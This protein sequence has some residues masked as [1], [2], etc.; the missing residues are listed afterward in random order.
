MENRNLPVPRSDFIGIENIIHLATGGEPPLL[1]GHRNAF[2]KFAKD[3]AQ[4]MPGYMRHWEQ[5]EAARW[6]LADFFTLNPEDIGLIGNASEGIVKVL[7]SI[8]WNEGDNVVVSELDY[9]SGRYALGNLKRRGVKVRMVP[10]TGWYI[11][12]DDLKNAC[13]DKTRVVYISQVNATTGQFIDVANISKYLESSNAYLIL[14]ASHALGVVPIQGHLA[15]FTVSS[16]YKFALGIHEGIF[17]W[18][19][20]RTRDFIPFG[21]GWSSATA[22]EKRD[23]FFLKPGAKRV[24]YGNAGHLG[25]YLLNESLDY[26]NNF[27][28]EKISSHAREMCKKIIE[29]LNSNQL[30]VITPTAPHKIAG[31]AAFAFNEPEH[32]VKRAAEDGILV[33]GDNNRVR[34]SAHVFTTAN[35]VDVFLGNLPKYLS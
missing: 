16:C 18:N 13:D 3:K 4:G 23:E 2:E 17:A 14:D 29:G 20:S 32:F 34:I 31:N 19:Q 10:A 28:I 1:A 7:S 30:E 24:E 26:L 12:T 35:D 11:N 8:D 21:V 9:T 15:D 6:K 27:G 5:V 33:W 25:A 22:G